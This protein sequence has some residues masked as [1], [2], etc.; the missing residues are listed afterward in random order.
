[1]AKFYHAIISMKDR[2]ATIRLSNH[3]VTD[4]EWHHGCRTYGV[5]MSPLDLEL[6]LKRK[7]MYDVLDIN[8]WQDYIISLEDPV[9]VP[10][11]NFINVRPIRDKWDPVIEIY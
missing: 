9:L 1:M 7:K 5:D 2:C 4:I 8:Q 3:G 10:N 11:N 6:D